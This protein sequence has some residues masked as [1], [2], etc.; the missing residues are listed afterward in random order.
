MKKA[1]YLCS[2]LLISVIISQ[3]QSETNVKTSTNVDGAISTVAKNKADTTLKDGWVKAGTINIS[4]TELGQNNYWTAVKGGGNTSFFGVKGIISYDFNRKKGKTNWLNSLNGRYAGTSSS[5]Y[6]PATNSSKSVPFTKSDDYLNF[7]SIYGKEFSKEW[8][9]AAFFSLES[10]FERFMTPGY[11][12]LGPGFLYK[13]SNHFNLLISPAMS[14]LTTKL[15]ASS[16]PLSLY[17]VDAGKKV[18]FGL[19][20]YARASFSYDLSKG[21]LYTGFADVYS[22]YLKNPGNLIV[23]WNNL[24][25][26]TVNKYI[27][28]TVSFNLRYNDLEVARMQTQHGIGIGFNYKF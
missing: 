22:N 2:L 7:S 27:A 19:G 23:N 11:I 9:Y 26:F 8:S 1:I 15:T 5:V 21:I 13:P 3:A 14:N 28:A 20:A 24:F 18:A 10:Q 4:L 17:G 12:K 16:K 6:V 25:A